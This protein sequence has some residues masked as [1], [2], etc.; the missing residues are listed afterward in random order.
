MPPNSSRLRPRSRQVEITPRWPTRLARRQPAATTP[1]RGRGRGKG[2]ADVRATYVRAYETPPA[3]PR[4]GGVRTRPGLMKYPP[5]VP[6]PYLW[7]R[8]LDLGGISKV[9]SS[10]ATSKRRAEGLA[11]RRL[12][13]TSLYRTWQC[14]DDATH[15]GQW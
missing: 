5:L 14:T 4:R 2:S 6:Q 7:R 15:G 11:R 3:V 10:D 12:M 13:T 8:A 1:G 9:Y